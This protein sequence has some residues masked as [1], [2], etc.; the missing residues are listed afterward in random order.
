MPASMMSVSE[1]SACCHFHIQ[2]MQNAGSKIYQEMLVKA[3]AMMEVANRLKY[4][5]WMHA[6]SVQPYNWW[7]PTD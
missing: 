2:D 5:I 1:L 4:S 3:L 6:L 7:Q